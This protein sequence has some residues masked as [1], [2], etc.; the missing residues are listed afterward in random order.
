MDY[1]SASEASKKWGTSLRQVQRLLNASR[2]PHAKKLGNSWVIPADAEKPGDPRFEKDQL[3]QKSLSAELAEVVTATTLPMPRS[4][5]DAI[6]DTVK[7]ERMRLHYES[8]LAY[9]QGDFE[10]VK[11]LF[12]KTEGDDASRLRGC[13]LAIAA[14]ISTGDYPFYMDIETYLKGFIK[15]DT[16]EEIKI[17]AELML[18]SASAGAIAP[19]MAPEWLKKGDFSALL[20]QA[21]IDAT[22]KRAKYFQALGQFE[23]MLAIAQT[24][25]GFHVAKVGFTFHDISFPVVCAAACCGLGRLDEAK[26][27]LADALSF[28][29]PHGFITPFAESATAFGGLLEQILEQK[30]PGYY[31]AV[32]DAWQR[33]YTNW[34]TFH[35]RFTK[36]NITLILSL[37]DYQIAQ[38]AAQGIPFKKIAEHFHISLGTLNNNMQD[39]Y[40]KLYIHGKKELKNYVF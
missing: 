33:T 40:R 19:N 35:N 2:I 21:K 27:Y 29:L 23:S 7:E 17:F 26:N 24:A 38:M 22:Y 6:L 5:P 36:D 31:K 15:A 12:Q 30:F 25:L 10:Q 9:L 13:S 37:R 14:A 11:T 32:T 18:A 39:I 16:S 20:P 8:E 34:V 28:A 1:I 3:P 4:N